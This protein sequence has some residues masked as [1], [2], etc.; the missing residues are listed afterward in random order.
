MSETKNTQNRRKKHYNVEAARNKRFN[1]LRFVVAFFIVS[2]I[3]LVG[4]I[5]YIKAEYGNEYEREAIVQHVIKNAIDRTI[6]P[7][8]G[9]IVDRYENSQP[10]AVSSTVYYVI[11]DAKVYLEVKEKIKD[12]EK[13]AF[14]EEIF[15]ALNR[16]FG[17]SYDDLEKALSENPDSRYIRIQNKVTGTQK[18]EFE[19]EMLELGRKLT[20]VWFEEDTL[21]RYPGTKTAAALIGFTTGDNSN[22]GIEAT[23]NSE[24]SGRTGRITR[25]YDKDSNAVTE[26][27]D[28]V[29]GHTVVTTID[30]MIQ[31]EAQRLVAQYGYESQAENV[32]LIVL[33]PKTGQ[34]LSMAQYPS[35]DLND[36]YNIDK[37]DDGDFKENL[38][39]ME[40]SKQIEAMYKLWRNFNIS[41]TFE[42]G[43]IYKPLVVAAALEEGVIVPESPFYCSGSK[44]ILDTTIP[45]N[46]YVAHGHQN[47]KDVLANSC[48]VGMMEINE[49]LGREKYYKYQKD[50]GIGELTGI[51]LPGEGGNSS[52]LYHTAA[53]LNPVELAAASMGQGHNMTAI[54]MITAFSSVING[55][56]L[57][58]PYIV[59][60]ILDENNNIVKENEPVILRK[61]VSKETSDEIRE[62]L[63]SVVT[64]G[65]AKKAAIEGY[66]I[67]GKTGTAQQGVK[68]G[69]GD[70][71]LTLSFIEYFPVDD[72]QYVI[73]TIVDKPKNYTPGKSPTIP[74]AKDLTNFIIQY[75][76]ISPSSSDAEFGI[77]R[78]DTKVLEDFKGKGISEAL[79]KLNAEGIIYEVS[80]SGS[81]VKNQLPA[82][83]TRIAKGSK[84]F[85]T[86][87][88]STEDEELAFVPNVMGMYSNQASEIITNAGLVPV[89]VDNSFEN[90]KAPKTEDGSGE[91]AN[92]EETDKKVVSQLIREIRV[93]K[94]TEVV[95]YVE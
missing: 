52:F 94:N 71:P 51:D 46:D 10:L 53:T 5:F 88:E 67:G 35:F 15:E 87:E 84:I 28:P 75:K 49:K 31:Q 57:M 42:P 26:K 59:S 6:Y 19:N 27:I 3:G 44:K 45:C 38:K 72:P 8:R 65:T 41:H 16:I 91:G 2:L 95:V 66:R 34:V 32:G 82:A 93:E 81:I 50:F 29:K 62:D 48:N 30:L 64:S 18:E 36:P 13:Q 69:D 86:L 4:R 63:E 77:N 43:S 60:Q 92:T 55:G 21:R 40:E 58:K 14:Q 76:R 12:E 23:Y 17:V 68:T 37:V 9:T 1:K 89:I 90:I 74:M 70:E 22:W 56:N 24:L 20:C 7:N 47:V 78:E 39:L 80:G 33:D 73:M 79:R 61:V 11:F 25:H 54:Q 83:G 85:L